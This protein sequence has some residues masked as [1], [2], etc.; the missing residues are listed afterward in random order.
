MKSNVSRR[1]FIRNASVA[2]GVGAIGIPGSSLQAELY[3]TPKTSPHD[4]N[5]GTVSVMDLSA[6]SASEMVQ[7]VI[8]I[9][10]GMVTYKP[11]II[12]LPEIFAYTNIS[13]NRYQVKDIAEEAP[14]AVVTPFLNFAA[15]NKC[16]VICPTYTLSDGNIY[17]SA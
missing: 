17:I 10:E 5:I 14:G 4:V 7:K 3:Q 15:T 13:N 12:C 2:L 16:Y 11:D 9:M 6:S 1:K 8:R